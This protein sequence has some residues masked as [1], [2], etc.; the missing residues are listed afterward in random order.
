M[1]FRNIITCKGIEY[2]TS[3]N[4]IAETL[5]ISISDMTGQYV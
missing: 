4:A 1:E 2:Q 3:V 5:S